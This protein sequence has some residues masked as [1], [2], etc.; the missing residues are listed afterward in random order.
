MSEFDRNPQE[1]PSWNLL[2]R[3]TSGA[4]ESVWREFVVRHEAGLIRTLSRL[5]SRFEPGH[6][7]SRVE[8]L[9]QEVYCRLFAGW[10][11][12][13]LRFRGGSDGEV[14]AY[15]QRVARSVV[16]DARRDDRAGKRGGGRLISLEASDLE[17]RLAAPAAFGAENRLLQRERRQLFLRRCRKA[18]GRHASETS[19]RVAQ[20]ALLDG[21]TSREIATALPGEISAPAVD[22]LVHR[23]R[24]SFE[25]SGTRL[26]RRAR[27]GGAARKLG[28]AV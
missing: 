18:L 12:E 14:G 10:R 26:P 24:K 8:D 3:C 20:M 21:W 27:V 15:L 19:L 28:V 4:A 22:L 23:L 25:L 13:R 7:G 5:W 1:E 17:A 9:L 16:M 6:D 2:H 11:R